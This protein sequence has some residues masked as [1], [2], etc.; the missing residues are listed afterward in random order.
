[1]NEKR[2]NLLE[3][4][5]EQSASQ[6]EYCHQII[7]AIYALL[8]RDEVSDAQPQDLERALAELEDLPVEAQEEGFPVPSELA[9]SHAGRLI[10][11]L[12]GVSPRKYFIY[13]TPDAEVA[14]DAPGPTGNSVLILCDSDGGALC[15]VN[16]KGKH[17]RAR[18]ESA[19]QL[20]DGFVFEALT[21]LKRQDILSCD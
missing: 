9:F 4:L 3:R 20:P 16:T 10:R 14:I 12:H 2:S 19:D 18:Y 11:E 1:M 13:P 17:R 8:S 5:W 7:R 6:H 21:E 15:L